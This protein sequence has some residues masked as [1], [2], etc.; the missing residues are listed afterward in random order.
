MT[1]TIHGVGMSTCAKRVGIILH[2]KQIPFILKHVDLA[3]KQH[4]S[5]GHLEKQPFGQVPYLEDDRF[6]LFES[7][8]IGKYL[9]TKYAGQ[10]TQDLVP[11]FGDLQAVAKF[12]QASSIEA[13]DFEGV[14]FPFV[15]EW[16]MRLRNP[17]HVTDQ[18]SITKQAEI[19]EG[20]LDGYE[21]IL[22]KQRYLAGDNLTV[23]DLFHLP[24]GTIVPTVLAKDPLDNQKRPNV[25]RWW[26][27]LQAR[28][29]WLAV[30]DG[31]ESKERYN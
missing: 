9:A 17:E 29:S 5:P 6:F 12:D 1:L 25:A 10:G 19:L 23:V 27:E 14:V 8:A 20:K 18:A 16:F 21:R 26:K 11:D 7:R 3:T 4:K 30:K 2:E 15:V 28:P 31:V 24:H 22:A 13:F